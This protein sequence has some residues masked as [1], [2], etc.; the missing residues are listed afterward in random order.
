MPI[1]V[2]DF[3]YLPK[4]S[5]VL[6]LC[7]NISS[8]IPT[9][10]AYKFW[11]LAYFISSFL[12]LSSLPDAWFTLPWSSR[13]LDQ[14]FCLPG[15]NYF[16]D[17][18]EWS[19]PFLPMTQPFISEQLILCSSNVLCS[20]FLSCILLSVHWQINTKVCYVATH[21]Q[22]THIHTQSNFLKF[23]GVTV[24]VTPAQRLK[25]EMPSSMKVKYG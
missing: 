20:I 21:P 1:C 24:Q 11:M 16:P 13:H 25:L 18:L 19:L 3:P 17:S 6:E 10:P 4:S 2:K 14:T 22:C 9:I 23:T 8:Y 7:G 15:P 5:E 12:P